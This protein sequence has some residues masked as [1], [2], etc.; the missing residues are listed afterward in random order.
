MPWSGSLLNREMKPQNHV[1][2]QQA[3]LNQHTFSAEQLQLAGIPTEPTL[4]TVGYQLTQ[5]QDGMS[6]HL[7]VCR[8]NGDLLYF[9]DLDNPAGAFGTVVPFPGMPPGTPRITS[10]IKKPEDEET[11][12]EPEGE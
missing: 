12:A 11:P 8:D 9:Y 10:K 2:W 7:V 4:L 1:S 3:D 6:A 5:A